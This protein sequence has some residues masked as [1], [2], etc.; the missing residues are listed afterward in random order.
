[1]PVAVTSR[2]SAKDQTSVMTTLAKVE[3]TL[4]AIDMKRPMLFTVGQ[5]VEILSKKQIIPLD[6]PLKVQ[7]DIY[8]VIIVSASA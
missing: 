2:I 4:R 5:Y 1:M 6:I 3:Q 7:E 8:N